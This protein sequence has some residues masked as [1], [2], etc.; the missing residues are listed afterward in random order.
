MNLKRF[1]NN[2]YNQIAIYIIVVS[3]IVIAINTFMGS[4]PFFFNLIVSR[5]AWLANA[6]TP[7]IIALVMAYLL[8]P[9]TNCFQRLIMK[10]KFFRN[11]ETKSRLIAVLFVVLLLLLVIAGVLSLIIFSITDQLRLAKFQDI[12]VVAE[13]LV[14][15]INDLY[16]NLVDKL[17]SINVESEEVN[18]YLKQMG[19]VLLEKV[20]SIS[21]SI[22]SSVTG[23]TSF[24]GK[25]FFAFI[26]MIYFL[27]D[28]KEIKRQVSRISKALLS[29]KTNDKINYVLGEADQVFSG[30][31]RGQFMD[32]AFMMIALSVILSILGVR[33]GLIIGI[34]AG[35]GNLIPYFGPFVGYGGVILV[36]GI[37]G[38]VKLMIISIIALLILQAID[39]N[40]IGPKLLS[41]CIKI[42]PLIVI[43]SLVFGSAIGGLLGM[44]LAVPVGALIKVLFMNYIDKRIIEKERK[45]EKING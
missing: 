23:V 42:H 9:L 37:S 2:K 4:M 8:F 34:C 39:G 44:L 41:N 22:I 36:C 40:I 30:Y 6:S 13:N 21:T 17:G 33:F 19:G 20:A 7:I 45:E 16:N 32:A 11:K 15:S 3:A 38:D 27:I 43:I 29:N 12:Y 25:L 5:L 28:G 18:A 26:M 1:I 35:L 31:I 24:F 10:I 14:K